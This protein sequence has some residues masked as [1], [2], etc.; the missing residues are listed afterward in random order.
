MAELN[1]KLFGSIKGK[2]GD[3][4]FRHRN[5]KNYIAQKP[6]KYT[7]PDNESFR[8][9]TTKF[10]L[11]SIVSSSINSVTTLKEIWKL[12]TPKELSVYNYLISKNYQAVDNGTIGSLFK[13]VPDGGFGA[14]L[15]T[16]AMDQSSL[17]I[18][19]FPLTSAS[20]IDVTLE[21]KVQSISLVALSEP[22]DINLN[23]VEILILIS[24]PKTVDL[25]NNLEF[26][27]MLSTA[28]SDLL[29]FYNK[30]QIFST[31]ITYDEND[32]LVQFAKTFSFVI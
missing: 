15:N 26:I 17:T 24:S 1:K 32:I 5:G 20:G 22:T 2:F 30:K 9:R 25:E 23:P 19:L 10:K 13:I 3:A 8:N 21:K 11:L 12:S 7:L 14:R 31:L 28:D 29:S 16:L 6:K 27:T 18:N 4:V